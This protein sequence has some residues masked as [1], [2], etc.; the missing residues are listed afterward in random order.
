MTTPHV[1]GPDCNHDHDHDHDHDHHHHEDIDIESKVEMT[2]SVTG[3]LDVAV[4]WDRVNKE[5]QKSYKEVAKHAR[6]KGF[7]QGK[8]PMNVVKQ[9]YG[10]R[11]RDEVTNHLVE[12]GLLLA[13]Q[14]HELD[15]VAQ[16]HV[17]PEPIKD[18]QPL[19]FKASVEVRPKIEKVELGNFKVEKP[20]YEVE[21]G[22]VDRELEAL[23]LQN[24]DIR[25]PEPMRPAQKYDILTLDYQ[26]RADGETK[27]QLGASDREVSLGTDELADEFEA[28][29]LGL[30][31]GESKTIEMKCGEDHPNPELR[32]K[33]A[34]FDVT[35][36]GL[37]E[38]LLPDLDDD[39][40]KDVGD[41][42]TLLDLR[43]KTRKRLEQLTN[44][45]SE[46]SLKR[47]LIDRL[48]ELNPLEVPQ[49]LVSREQQQ[50]LY[51]MASYAYMSQQPFDAESAQEAAKESGIRRVKAALL[52]GA[53]ARQEQI[54][55]EPAD[56]DA[57]F[58]EIAEATGKHIAKVKA[59]YADRRDAIENEILEEKLVGHLRSIAEVTERRI[60]DDK[61]EAQK[62][63]D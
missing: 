5:L 1:H 27:E 32:G 26:V 3:E 45:Q 43:M 42:E 7:R 38:R 2:S 11:V 61:T 29:L 39:F 33:T 49:S 51:Q 23:R 13:L 48:I 28:G 6:L 15:I 62:D 55:F 17:T 46:A 4:P 63:A 21:D 44:D 16:P 24:A 8:A 53:L 36:K 52:L 30:K 47:A 31:P 37:R 19:R 10:K 14:K 34:Q 58:A 40:A 25:T 41:Y 20:I 35:V 9:M 22:D 50:S 54:N 60:N 56:V 18:K 59:E 12:L 57:K